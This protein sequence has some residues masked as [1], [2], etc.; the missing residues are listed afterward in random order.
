[1]GLQPGRDLSARPGEASGHP[2]EPTVRGAH[3]E[4]APAGPVLLLRPDAGA[5]ADTKR[6]RAAAQKRH[7][8]QLYHLLAAHPVRA[9]GGKPG[10]P[11]PRC[12][13]PL[14]GPLAEE[15]QHR[16][17]H[18]AV[19]VDLPAAGHRSRGPLFAPAQQHRDQRHRLAPHHA[20]RRHGDTRADALH[21]RPGVLQRGGAG[22]S[23][24]D[25]AAASGLY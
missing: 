20:R 8:N 2:A 23:R 16:D 4:R 3:A 1:P 6:Q 17:V 12:P 24:D 25:Q 21:E 13:A 5:G 18:S 10:P 7:H 19:L 15:L 11:G 22:G 9:P 14:H